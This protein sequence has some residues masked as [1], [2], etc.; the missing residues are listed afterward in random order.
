MKHFR[1]TRSLR[2]LCSGRSDSGSALER[3]IVYLAAQA[4]KLINVRGANKCAH[5]TKPKQNRCKAVS[6][7]QD[8][9]M[10]SAS[11]SVLE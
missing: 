5:S 3:L 1:N 4:G 8:Y 7:I 2:L 10:H 9:F 11:G 6:G